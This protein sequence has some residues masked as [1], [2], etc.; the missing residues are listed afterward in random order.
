MLSGRIDVR[1]QMQKPQQPNSAVVP[2][3]HNRDY[4]M[5]DWPTRH[6]AICEYT[7]GREAD[8]VFF[9]DSI[10]H[11][12]GGAPYDPTD[13]TPKTGLAAWNAYFGNWRCVNLGCG[14][15]RTENVL[16]RIANG[17]ADGLQAR[18]F[19][20]LIGTNNIGLNTPR[21]IRDG[22]VAVADELHRRHPEARILVL[23]VLP[24]GSTPED[25][26]R[27]AA[28]EV[29]RLLA[30]LRR[31]YLRFADIGGV[32]LERDGSIAPTTMPD[33]LHPTE[34]AYRAM[35]AAIVPHLEEWLGVAN[36]VP[37]DLWPDRVLTPMAEAVDENLYVRNVAVP[38][39]VP[40]LPPAGTG[41]GTA[42]VICPGGAYYL[43]DWAAHVIRLARRFNPHGIAVVGVR[44]RTAPPTP[45]V[46]GDALEDLRRAIR[47]TVANADRWR[48]HPDRLVGLGY[49]AGSNLLLTHASTD[50]NRSDNDA[51]R[52]GPTRLGYQ[53]LMCLWPHDKPV[54]A[55]AIRPN[56]PR[57]FL[58]TTAEDSVAPPAF[59]EGIGAAIRAAGG[60][61]EVT[62]FPKGDHLAF[63]FREDGPAVDWTES[64][65]SWLRIC[66]LLN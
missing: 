30:R 1:K 28:A 47:I 40:F 2:D 13:T 41:N 33:F 21:E 45:N 9:G 66:K 63:N 20:L 29:N 11:R 48:I 19:V 10:T 37:I 4:P 46:P 22:I 7:T 65:L 15:D 32:L 56:P 58:C 25:A 57:T 23:G 54:S 5:Y 39:V 27:Q 16:W 14:Y 35:A 60:Q 3:T 42:I 26:G 17:Q 8:V 64:F 61:A 18:V 6:R 12:W 52:R 34:V 55:Y 51:L 38:Q 62:I 43:L 59:S 53:A 44:Y 49:S 24:R 36:G 50:D 31:P